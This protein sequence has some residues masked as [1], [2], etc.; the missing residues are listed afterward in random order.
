PDHA[1]SY[2][3]LSEIAVEGRYQFPPGELDRIKAFAANECCPASERSHFNFAVAMML[4]QQ[5]SHDEAFHY[6]QQANDLRK[7]LNQQQNNVF[8][9]GRHD[10]WVD[11]IIATHD[12]AY[13]EQVRDWG[14]DTELPVFIV[15]MPRTGSTLVEQIL[16]S[17]PRVFGAGEL[18]KIPRLIAKLAAQAN[19]ELYAAPVAP[20]PRA[21][22]DLAAAFLECL[23]SVPEGSARVT[24]KNLDNYLHLGL[25]ATLFP[26]AR[27]I[28]CRRD[29]IDSCLAC[30]FQNFHDLIFAWSLEDIG[31]CYRSY[32]KL[33]AHWSRVLPLACLDLCYEEL[34]HDQEGVTR[35]L[36]DFC[37]LNW[38][39]RCL[40]FYNTR[41]VVR[42]ASS[43]QVRKP[44]SAHTIGRWTHYRDHLEPLFRALGRWDV[45]QAMAPEPV[46]QSRHVARSRTLI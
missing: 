13:F 9:A 19:G 23:P 16:T 21:A 25:I 14:T 32:E 12:R 44:I 41:R 2:Y 28:H 3:N 39:E 34:V 30:Y 7:H 38:D 8:D 6:Y 20:N 46:Y 42:T 4:N 33:M 1:L 31:A 11:L 17:H 10:S 26:R 5:G 36:L 24:I 27:I 22:G 43:L 40:K 37:G 45:T 35:K 15:G 18:I 29:A